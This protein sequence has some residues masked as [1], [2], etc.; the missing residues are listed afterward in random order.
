[1]LFLFSRTHHDIAKKTGRSIVVAENQSI[2]LNETTKSYPV[3]LDEGLGFRMIPESLI[4]KL[5][6]PNSITQLETDLL[7]TLS[8]MGDVSKKTSVFPVEIG[9]ETEE[10]QWFDIK[11]CVGFLA[12]SLKTEKFR[13]LPALDLLSMCSLKYRN[14]A[15]GFGGGSP[16]LSYVSAGEHLVIKLLYS[17]SKQSVT[18]LS[19]VGNQALLALPEAI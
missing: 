16:L 9:L 1:M 8:K 6:F 5:R 18:Q 3:F 15:S 12:D 17:V 7:E 13:I 10:I 2:T 4:V 19:E 11:T 14:G